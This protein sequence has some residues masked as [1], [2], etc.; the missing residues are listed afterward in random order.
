MAGLMTPALSACHETPGPSGPQLALADFS[1]ASYV[2]RQRASEADA[3]EA[4]LAA[5]LTPAASPWRGDGGRSDQDAFFDVKAQVNEPVIVDSLIGQVNG[6]PIYADEVLAP[7]MDRLMASY[8]TDPYNVFQQRMVQL[9]SEQLKA[10]VDNELLVAESRASLT[11]E[12]QGGLMAFM[13]QFKQ[14]VVRKRGGVEREAERQLLEEEGKTFDEFL[15]T[16]QQKMLIGELMRDRLSAN[17]TVSWKD[18]ERAYQARLHEFQPQASVALGRIRLRTEGQQAQIN[19]ISE[20]L[21]AG[22]PFESVAS[23]AGMTEEGF[24]REFPMPKDGLEALPLADFYKP[25]VRDLKTGMTSEAFQRG[26]W[27]IWVSV[28]YVHQPPHRSLDDPE[29]Q[30]LLQQQLTMMRQGQAQ[31]R[32]MYSLTERGIFD[33]VRD[34]AGRAVQIAASRFPPPQ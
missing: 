6:R 28:L 10:V 34:M 7:L 24:W 5:G 30:R 16:E 4:L 9:V 18:V 27:T 31:A 19:L 8:R 14:D 1:D 12:Q 11:S 33:D 20:E 15:D 26:P 22:A 32:F 13:D 2:D 29:V 3:Q 23:Q 17:T 21:K 25:H